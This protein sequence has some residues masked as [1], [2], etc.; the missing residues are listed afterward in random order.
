M[1]ENGEDT[2]QAE[3]QQV[4]LQILAQYIRDLSFENVVA[5]KGFEGG[6]ITPDIEVQVSLDGR[7]RPVEGQ[8]E[9]VMKFQITS[10][11][12]ADQAN[13]FLLELEY[14]GIFFIDGVPEEQMHPFLLIE[15]PRQLF[16]FVRRIVSDLTNDGG[17]PQLNLD[18]IDFVDLY[19]QQM[20]AQ[21]GQPTQA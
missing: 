4:R 20:L 5:Q 10:K 7:Q 2:L 17:F 14:G 11:N 9:V 12:Q 15:C 1:A 3:D 16:P 19:R 13:L 8:Y 21:Q 18:N 6:E